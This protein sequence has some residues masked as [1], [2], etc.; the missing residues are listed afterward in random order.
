MTVRVCLQ[1]DVCDGKHMTQ[2]GH[3]D[4]GPALLDPN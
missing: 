3:S 2:D 4:F 1:I